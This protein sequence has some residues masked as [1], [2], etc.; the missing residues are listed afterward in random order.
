M[1]NQ[2]SMAQQETILTLLGQGWSQRRIA[3]ELGLHRGTVARHARLRLPGAQ[4]PATGPPDPKQASTGE[5]AT[6]SAAPEDSKQ[7]TLGQVATGSEPLK[8]ARKSLCEPFRDVISGKL[9][10]GLSA[11]RIYQDLVTE[12]GFGGAYNSVKRMVRRLTSAGALPFRRMECEPGAE[13]QCDFGT[14]APLL[15]ADGKRRRSHVL[16]MS[17]SYSRKAYSEVVLQQTTEN[18]LACLENAFWYWGG[19]PKTLV[20][21]NLKAAVLQADWFDPVLHPKIGA[22]CRHYGTVL[23]PTKPRTP[24]HKGKIESGIKYV[25]ENALKGRTFS[26]LPAQNEHLARWE[27]RVADLRIHGTTKKQVQKLFESEKTA[28]L[29]LPAGRFP[30]F[31]EGQRTVHRDGHIEVAKAYYSVPPEYLGRTVWVRWDSRLVRVFNAHFAE[32]ALH[33][34]HAAGRFSTSDK[35]LAARKISLVERGSTELLGRARRIG[36]QAGRWAEAMLKERGIPGVRVL[37]GLL[38]L[39]RKHSSLTVDAACELAL[40][41]GAFR[42]R[43]LRALIKKPAQQQA[44]DFMTEHPIIRNLHDYGTLVKVRFGQPWQAPPTQPPKDPNDH[45]DPLEGRIRNGPAPVLN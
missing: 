39:A 12:Q 14:G 18:L 45:D 10:A 6:G 35:H 24:R 3:R 7:A 43:A 23:L 29:P 20:T 13:A 26:S 34:R 42:L 21:D 44:L 40:G 32:I 27:R 22:F 15:N 9:D 41:H 4:G 37:L 17:L 33:P 31:N 5:V 28:L 11:Q 36:P 38:A 19:V 30:C 1:S 2:L 25:Q 16:R 8:P